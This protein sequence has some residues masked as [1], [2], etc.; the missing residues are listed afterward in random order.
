M[1]I[2][3]RVKEG[4]GAAS[5]SRIFWRR[6]CLICPFIKDRSGIIRLYS[7]DIPA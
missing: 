3:R 2:S 4:M 6:S 1:W 7:K 5:A